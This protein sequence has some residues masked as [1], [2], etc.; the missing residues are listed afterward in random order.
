MG[1]GD[2]WTDIQVFWIDIND[3]SEAEKKKDRYEKVASELGN[4]IT[5]C[6]EFLTQATTCATSFHSSF[7]SNGNAFKGKW[8]TKFDEKEEVWNTNQTKLLKKMSEALKTAKERRSEAERLAGE[9]A[10]TEKNQEA[11]IRRDLTEKKEEKRK[12]SEEARKKA[13]AAQRKW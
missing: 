7:I 5:T 3:Y 9:W 2:I 6:E 4:K 10:Q 12:Q 13:L 1:L 11:R 8:K